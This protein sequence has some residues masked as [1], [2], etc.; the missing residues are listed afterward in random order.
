MNRVVM[1]AH[2]LLLCAACESSENKQLTREELLDPEACKN[3]HPNHYREWASSMHAYAT[4][5]PVFLAMNRRGQEETAGTDAEIGD[6]CVNCH[7]PM[8]VRENA[9]DDFAELEDLPQH[10]KGVTCYFCHNVTSVDG[11]HNAMLSLANDTTM[12][13][14]IANPVQ[15][16]AHRAQY[17]EIHD[18]DSAKS[19]A[20]CGACHDIVTH[21]G[22]HL[23]RTFEEY[24]DSLFARPGLG[25]STCQTCH[26]NEYRGIAADDPE[27]GVSQR[28]VHEHMWPGVDVALT[29]FPD[30]EAQRLAVECDLANSAF[31][32]SLDRGE[33]PTDFKVVLETEAGHRQPSGA[34]Q[35]RRMWLELIA[36]DAAGEVIFESGTIEDDESEVEAENDPD[37]NRRAWMFRDRLVGADGEEVHMFWEAVDF[38]SETLPFR[39]S[40]SPDH[41]R[42]RTYRLPAEPA[43]ITTRMRM[44]PMGF[45][46]LQS[47]VDSGHLEEDVI[48]EMPTLPMYGGYGEWTP[49]GLF[50]RDRLPIDCPP[51]NG[52]LF[53]DRAAEC[54]GR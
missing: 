51:H 14:G 47:L 17:S 21:A 31:I 53:D 9:I 35:D 29:D 4:D 38:Q 49:T 30:R 3:C 42:E 54:G 16:D 32:F 50:R 33:L 23:E 20:V 12:R 24:Q 46:V 27:S 28:I 26:M 18:G 45:D 41:V 25:F 5:D 8:A 1:L 34:A 37:E 7:A 6:F 19:S 13:G 43:R 2:A 22:V 44:R 10:L 11:D 40:L 15:P 52:C 48:A 39:T 36:Y